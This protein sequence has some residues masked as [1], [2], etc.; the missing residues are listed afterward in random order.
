MSIH[1]LLVLV[2]RVRHFLNAIVFLVLFGAPLANGSV[3]P[4]FL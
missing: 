4:D 3:G 1:F 2:G